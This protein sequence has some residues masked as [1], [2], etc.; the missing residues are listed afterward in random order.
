MRIPPIAQKRQV[1]RGTFSDRGRMRRRLTLRPAAIP[2]A[3]S[4]RL[5]AVRRRIGSSRVE[6]LSIANGMCALGAAN[7]RKILV[8][9]P[10][11]L[12]YARPGRTV[13]NAVP[14]HAIMI[15]HALRW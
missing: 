13:S 11:R 15:A 7:Q 2:Q 5:R 12:S 4:R 3:V 14:G 8:A 6:L 10:A 1:H 9:A